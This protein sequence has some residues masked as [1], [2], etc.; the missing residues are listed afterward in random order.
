MIYFFASLGR[1]IGDCGACFYNCGNLGAGFNGPRQPHLSS[2]SHP[3]TSTHGPR[4]PFKLSPG[5]V[6]PA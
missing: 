3:S 6:V 2:P 4:S 5:A 1:L